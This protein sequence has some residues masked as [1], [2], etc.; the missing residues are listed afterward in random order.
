MLFEET[1]A[2]YCEKHTEHSDTLWGYRA[3]FYSVKAGGTHTNH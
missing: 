2:V 3:E 1:V